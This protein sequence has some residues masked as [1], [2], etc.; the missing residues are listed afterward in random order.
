MVE[1]N[2][3]VSQRKIRKHKPGGTAGKNSYQYICSLPIE[4]VERLGLEGFANFSFNG[5]QITIE[6][7]PKNSTM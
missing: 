6:P 1:I 4:W 2:V 5:K 7:M 3:E